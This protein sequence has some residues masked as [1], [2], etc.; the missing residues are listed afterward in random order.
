[1]PMDV[2]AAL[3]VRGLVWKNKTEKQL[4]RSFLK[5][6]T[7]FEAAVRPLAGYC[8]VLNNCY[9]VHYLVRGAVTKIRKYSCVVI[10]R[11]HQ[12]TSLAPLLLAGR[13]PLPAALA[14]SDRAITPIRK[15]R[16][17]EHARAPL[18]LNNPSSP[19]ILHRQTRTRNNVTRRYFWPNGQTI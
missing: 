10:I 12:R 17:R 18:C 9:P 15:D 19:T 1:M 5:V 2:A 7:S 3:P 13:A 4:E 14:S 16:S 11:P 6:K 8:K